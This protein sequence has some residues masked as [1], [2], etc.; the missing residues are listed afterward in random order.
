MVMKN[1]IP[2]QRSYILRLW[3]EVLEGKRVWRFSL[4]DTYSGE[5]KGFARPE[6][7]FTYIH[8]LLVEGEHD[9]GVRA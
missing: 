3:I 9:Y 6:E 7:L 4:E 8:T 2:N 1:D 5:R